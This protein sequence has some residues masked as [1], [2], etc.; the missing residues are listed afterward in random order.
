[1][2][3]TFGGVEASN[4]PGLR[5]SNHMERQNPPRRHP[6]PSV[7]SLNTVAAPPRITPVTTAATTYAPSI[8]AGIGGAITYTI[9]TVTLRPERNA[10]EKNVCNHAFLMLIRVYAIP[11]MR[12]RAPATPHPGVSLGCKGSAPAGIGSV[13][14]MLK[15]ALYALNIGWGWMGN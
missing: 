15:S 5:V 14:L 12:R 11:L 1:M 8:A 9:R 13:K 10:V 4:P 2:K 6:K 7:I 3:M